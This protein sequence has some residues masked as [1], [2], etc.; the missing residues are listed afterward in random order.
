M[1]ENSQIKLWKILL[2]FI[3]GPTEYLSF[4]IDAVGTITFCLDISF[5]SP[6]GIPASMQDGDRHESSQFI[7][8]HEI[9]FNDY[10]MNHCFSLKHGPLTDLFKFWEER[11][12]FLLKA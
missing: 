10:H 2:K 8:S 7:L 6:K 3:G 1:S 4:S 11:A 12:R 5:S 9:I